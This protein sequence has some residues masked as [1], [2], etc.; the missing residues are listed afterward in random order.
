[1]AYRHF[2]V[3][4]DAKN[5]IDADS[6]DENEMSN[7]A[8]VL[9]SSEMRT[10]LKIT[11]MNHA[12]LITQTERIW[13]NPC[14]SKQMEANYD[15]Q[16]IDLDVGLFAAIWPP[17]HETFNTKEAPQVGSFREIRRR[18]APAIYQSRH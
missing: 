5:I 3:S 2:G 17:R 7:A 9:R 4:L 6:N 13:Q 16:S 12:R 15:P 8:P 18:G 10:I 14:L 1:M 11:D